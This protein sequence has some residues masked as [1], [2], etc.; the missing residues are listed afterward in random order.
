MFPS[1]LSFFLSLTLSLS[2][3][4]TAFRLSWNCL[5][6]WFLAIFIFS[7][8]AACERLGMEERI[9]CGVFE[10]RVRKSIDKYTNVPTGS[11]RWENLTLRTSL[12]PGSHGARV[13]KMKKKAK[14]SKFCAVSS[15]KVDRH[16]DYNRLEG[17][18]A[19]TYSSPGSP[20]C[21]LWWRCEVGTYV[22][23]FVCEFWHQS[24]VASW[25]CYVV[26]EVYLEVSLSVFNLFLL[27]E[28]RWMSNMYVYVLFVCLFV[29]LYACMHIHVYHASMPR[30]PQG[31]TQVRFLWCM[32]WV[33]LYTSGIHPS[34]Q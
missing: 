33:C 4:N 24:N 8:V 17:L 22:C 15:R 32:C 20:A 14:C 1:F 27:Y 18:T 7:I 31:T 13:K 25:I 21:F 3:G 6:N 11:N 30:S 16:T 34:I 23:Q 9:V 26:C 2:L 12:S 19:R 28:G 10:L 29:C 5:P